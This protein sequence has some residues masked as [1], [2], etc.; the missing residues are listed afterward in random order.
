M[1]KD[2][3]KEQDEIKVVENLRKKELSDDIGLSE[4]FFYPQQTNKFPKFLKPGEKSNAQIQKE[5]VLE[6]IARQ[7]SEILSDEEYVQII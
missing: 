2:M 6:D 4:A 1:K 3:K 5:A 7:R